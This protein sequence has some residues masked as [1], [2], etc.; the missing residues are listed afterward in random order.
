MLATAASAIKSS[1]ASSVGGRKRAAASVSSQRAPR[2]MAS[3]QCRMD[4][5]AWC[6]SEPPRAEE[7]AD[8]SMSRDDEDEDAEGS[9]ATATALERSRDCASVS[10]SGVR[11]RRMHSSRTICGWFGGGVTVWPRF[12]AIILKIHKRD[13]EDMNNKTGA[14]VKYL[15]GIENELDKG[16]HARHRSVRQSVL[17]RDA[18][19][20]NQH[21]L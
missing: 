8:E 7:V 17:P 2:H 1:N 3:V 5:T 16:G 13:D 10:A 18:V 9:T 12:G 14:R 20:E 11:M 19:S 15:H 6:E 21:G 4:D